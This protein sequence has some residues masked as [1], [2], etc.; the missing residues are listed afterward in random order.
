M[1]KNLEEIIAPEADAKEDL[2]LEE[3]NDVREFLSDNIDEKEFIR[4]RNIRDSKMSELTKE[5]L[6]KVL[7]AG[8]KIWIA[9]RA[10]SEK[11]KGN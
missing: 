4:R 8:A 5:Q 7:D 2:R 1:R 10:E 11:Q 9:A 6:S 3:K